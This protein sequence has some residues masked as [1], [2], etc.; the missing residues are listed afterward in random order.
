VE[1]WRSDLRDFA[2]VFAFCAVCGWNYGAANIGVF[3]VI[4]FT[5]I[6]ASKT[7]SMFKNRAHGFDYLLVPVNTLEKTFTGIVLSHIY[8][9]L[10]Y[11]IA[12]VLGLE[13]GSFLYSF[14]PSN[15]TGILNIGKVLAW[16]PTYWNYILSFFAAL[17]LFVF[18]SVF[19]RKSAFGK[20]L[21]CYFGFALI[22]VIVTV[23]IITAMMKNIVMD[24][25]INAWAFT[26]QD[27]EFTFKNMTLL[28]K[29]STVGSNI[30]IILFG[31]VMSF[32]RLREKEA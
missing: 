2:M 5:L 14:H 30:F 7:F 19:F 8:R 22:I 28:G 25:S 3:F 18:A 26:M 6:A 31:W 32:L 1:R 10:L 27:Y 29:I 21:L 15:D 23:T 12:F 11:F 13:L 17:S 9:I 24:P 4:L 20:T 16:I